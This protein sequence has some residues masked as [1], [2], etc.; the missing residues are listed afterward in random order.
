MNDDFT[1]DDLLL[2]QIGNAAEERVAA[3]LQHDLADLEVDG[4]LPAPVLQ[5]MLLLVGSL[6]ANRE[7]I[8]NVNFMKLPLA[9]S[10]LLETYKNYKNSRY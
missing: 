8:S 9:Y 2:N 5:A 10:Y 6:Y 1:E 7:A 4:N 3:H